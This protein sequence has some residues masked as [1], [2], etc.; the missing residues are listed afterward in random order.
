MP[1]LDVANPGISIVEG[2]E[3]TLCELLDEAATTRHNTDVG[4]PLTKSDFEGFSKRIGASL[5]DHGVVSSELSKEEASSA[6]KRL[7]SI[8]ETAARVFFS[9]LIVS[10]P[11]DSPDFSRMWHLLDIIWI[12]CDD[13]I[14]DPTLPFILVED[15]LESQTIPGCRIVL[16]Y[17]ESRRER[18]V[19]KG[20]NPKQIPPLLR[21]CN[22]LLRRLSRAEDTAFCGRVFIFLFQSLPMGD[23]SSTNMKGEFHIDNI[24]SFEELNTTDDNKM[25]I[26]AQA[27]TQGEAEDAKKEV[28]AVPKSLSTDELYPMF[29][30]LQESFSQPEKLF[31]AEHFAKFKKD[32]KAVID[33]FKDI[34]PDESNRN[35]RSATSLEDA[36]AGLKR[37]RIRDEH[38]EP[39]EVFHPKYLTSKDLFELEVRLVPS[40]CKLQRSGSLM[41]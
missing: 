23:R 28:K 30:S 20:L 25:Y 22:E 33:K 38:D 19:A 17:L 34:Q 31:D 27:E 6:K 18:I 14:C 26:D 1:A 12:I 3:T 9:K 5:P 24:T 7:D 8:I 2:F 40:S 16:D 21:S 37:K 15:L 39:L 10:T 29:W 13:D 41:I 11:I 35:A 36:K 32:M 4:Q